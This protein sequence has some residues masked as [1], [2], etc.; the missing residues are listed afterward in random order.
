M[1]RFLLLTTTL[2]ALLSLSGPATQAGSRDGITLNG[3]ALDGRQVTLPAGLSVGAPAAEEAQRIATN[4]PALDGREVALPAGLSVDGASQAQ[5][6]GG[7]PMGCPRWGCGGN[8]PALGGWQVALPE[9]A[10]LAINPL[11][12]PG[13]NRGLLPSDQRWPA[14]EQDQRAQR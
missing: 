7:E 2:A 9:L 1:K 5:F 10:A 13:D 11:R 12:L 8:G 14:A 3:P 4:G 6:V